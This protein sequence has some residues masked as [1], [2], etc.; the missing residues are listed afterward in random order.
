[1]TSAR[2]SS[3]PLLCFPPSLPRVVAVPSVFIPRPLSL[4]L[5]RDSAGALPFMVVRRVRRL[6]FGEGVVWVEASL[7]MSGQTLS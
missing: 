1:M 6:P 5:E 3:F 2:A 7:S 4:S